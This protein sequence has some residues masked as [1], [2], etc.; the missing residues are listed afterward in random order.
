MSYEHCEKHNKPA[1]NGCPDCQFEEREAPFWGHPRPWGVSKVN[2]R[3]VV[4][5]VGM[6]VCDA[7]FPSV[8]ALI[9]QLANEGYL[10]RGTIK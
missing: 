2:P 7:V 1:T 5:S 4:S 9:V 3:T 6:Y 10:E 8:A